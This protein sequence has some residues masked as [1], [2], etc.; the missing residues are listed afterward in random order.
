M[1]DL[2]RN[3]RL[4]A[5]Q[6]HRPDFTCVH[7]AAKL[8]PISDEA[9]RLFQQGLIAT[10]YDLWPDQRDYKR[11][12]QL[13][14]QAAALGHWKATMNLADLYKRGLGV[15]RDRERAVLLIEGLMKQGVPAAFDMMG[16]YHQSGVGVNP[17]IDRA[18]AFWQLA[19]DMGSPAAQTYIGHKL[20]AAYDSKQM[21]VWANRTVAL[22]MLEC[23][24]AKGTEMQLT[25]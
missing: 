5:F 21:G 20:D 25:G 3:M 18:Y 24:F 19:A 8:P 12:A 14:E 7:E 6:P 23:A 2:P 17:D 9:E 13:W 10:S 22:Q 1:N 11:A 15:E 4:K 16:T